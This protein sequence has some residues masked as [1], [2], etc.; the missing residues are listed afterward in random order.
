[1]GALGRLAGGIAHDFNNRLVLIMGHAELLRSGLKVES[2]QAHHAEMVLASAKGAAELTRQLLAYSRRQV[3][4][5]EAFD[6]N[7]LVDRMQRLLQ[8]VIGERIELL[9]V[10]GAKREILADPGQIEQVI[11]NLALNARDAMPEGGNLTLET[12]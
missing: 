9:T 1:L 5:P 4:K 11:L 6:L 2:A 3:L 10:L 8:S 12:Q 7:D